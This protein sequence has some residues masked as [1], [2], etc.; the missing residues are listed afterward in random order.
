MIFKYFIILL[1]PLVEVHL[2]I[3]LTK[4]KSN[5]FLIAVI[6]LSMIIILTGS[7]WI[8]INSLSMGVHSSLEDLL[9]R[10]KQ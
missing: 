4:Y 2:A 3:L 6:I 9:K 5:K 8:F 10:M 1:T 7:I